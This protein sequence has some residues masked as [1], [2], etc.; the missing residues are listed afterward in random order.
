MAVPTDFSY[1][2]RVIGAGEV[3]GPVLEIG[4]RD[5]QGGVGNAKETCE[6]AG[7][8]WEGTDID[9]GPGVDFTLDILDREAVGAIDRRW[10]S[11]LLFNL[12]E[13]VYEPAIALRHAVSLVEPGGAA[14]VV[15]PSVWQLHDFPRDYW[16][17]MPDFFSEFA[18]RHELT[19]VEEHFCWLLEQ[20]ERIIPIDSLTTT[21]GQKQFP[22]RKTAVEVFGTF[23]A[24]ASR[25]I[26]RALHLTGQVMHFP[27]VGIGVVLRKAQ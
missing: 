20:N 19:L 2:R 7:L 11:V 18:R 13:H 1:L 8:S 17:P 12:L 21:S 4:S 5:H 23:R 9:A 6:A 24:T 22:G 16:R 14:V 10:S 25:Y 3:R 26:H 15:G 27:Q